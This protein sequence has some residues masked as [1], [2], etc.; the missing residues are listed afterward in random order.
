MT[1]YYFMLAN[2]FRDMLRQPESADDTRA[3]TLTKH[4]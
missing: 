1:T 2:M 4:C 3:V